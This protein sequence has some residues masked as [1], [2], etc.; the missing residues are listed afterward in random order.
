MYQLKITK[1]TERLALQHFNNVKGRL[2]IDIHHFLSGN[3]RTLR[4]E[5]ISIHG[6]KPS[7]DLLRYLSVEKNLK[8]LIVS[9]PDKLRDII[10]KLH[11]DA[12][13]PKKNL[14]R[15]LYHIFIIFG[16]EDKRF[17]KGVFY[18]QSQVGTCPY[19]NMADIHYIPATALSQPEKGVLDHFYPKEIYPILGLSFYNLI[20][21]CPSCNDVQHKSNKDVTSN[22]GDA[23]LT[24]M[25]IINPYEYQDRN[26]F[27][28]Y[29]LKSHW[30]NAENSDV[31]I[32]TA[33]DKEVGYNALLNLNGRYNTIQNRET[34]ISIIRKLNRYPD[35]YFDYLNMLPIPA[36]LIKKEFDDWGFH[37]R[38]D[39][40]Y[41]YPFNKFKLDILEK[42]RTD[43]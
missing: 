9:H 10:S 33:G 3:Y 23:S 7:E 41:K 32:L 34:V 31:D 36:C 20:P 26:F 43:M 27:F 13:D 40:I 42:A 19:C 38:R 8:E 24:S 22:K 15:I 30:E 11:S 35:T 2:L 4:K 16:Y 21:S 12:F 25:R 5:T 17:N 6:D 28:D 14:N 39:E 37:L 18:R 1:N 29:N